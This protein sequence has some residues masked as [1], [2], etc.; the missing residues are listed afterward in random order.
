MVLPISHSKSLLQGFRFRLDLS[1]RPNLLAAPCHWQ[2]GAEGCKIWT[3]VLLK[4]SSNSTASDDEGSS[5]AVVEDN[6]K[7]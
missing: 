7:V 5:G 3:L 6:F 2:T 4:S 1:D